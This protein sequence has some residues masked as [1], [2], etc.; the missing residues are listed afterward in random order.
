MFYDKIMA[1]ALVKRGAAQSWMSLFDEAIEDFEKIV[2]SDI[3]CGVL[4]QM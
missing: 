1:R 2:S 3:Y 4:G